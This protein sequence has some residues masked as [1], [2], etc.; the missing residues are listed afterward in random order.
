MI[1]M[2]YIISK[3]YR[4][5]VAKSIFSSSG[6]GEFRVSLKVDKDDPLSIGNDPIESCYNEPHVASG[7]ECKEDVFWEDYEDLQRRISLDVKFIS[8]TMDDEAKQ[9]CP[10]WCMYGDWFSGILVEM[11][12]IKIQD[13]IN[14]SA[15]DGKQ[16]KPF[17]TST[18]NYHGKEN[19]FREIKSP[20]IKQ[21]LDSN[22]IVIGE[23]SYDD[24][25]RTTLFGKTKSW[26]FEKEFRMCVPHLRWNMDV[27]DDSYF[28]MSYSED[29]IKKIYVVDKKFKTFDFHE[30]YKSKVSRL[31]FDITEEKFIESI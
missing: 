18:T 3:F 6:N 2:E 4:N 12:F 13:H 15:L 10:M 8:F 29:F 9:N 28:M 17:P 31:N 27:G 14:Q 22:N 16:T 23:V 5:D 25:K 21:A 11:D 1:H 19:F 20:D 30:R 7:E 26:S 24:V